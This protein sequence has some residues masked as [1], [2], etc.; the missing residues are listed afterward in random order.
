[1]ASR[2]ADNHAKLEAQIVEWSKTIDTLMAK[3][4]T[5][6][7]EARASAVKRIEEGKLKLASARQKLDALKTIGADKYDEAK[8]SLEHLW[9][10]AKTALE[11]GAF[12]A[13]K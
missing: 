7:D 3:A 12:I 13:P 1:M 6:K 10:E 8:A 9:Q 4:H 5:L 2:R 11:K